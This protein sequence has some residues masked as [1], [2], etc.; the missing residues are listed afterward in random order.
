M[1]YNYMDPQAEEYHKAHPEKPVIGTETVSAVGTRGIYVT[2][3]EKAMWARTIRT[4]RR[5]APRRKAGGASAIRGSGCREDSC[6]RG[7][8][9]AASRRPMSGPTS[10]RSMELSIPAVSL[11]IRFSTTSRGGPTSR[12]LHLFPHWNWPGM[13]GKEIAVWVY[14]NLDKVELFFNGKSLGAKDMKKDSHVAW[15]VKYAP[16]AIEA[17][18]Y[19]GGKVVMTAKRETTRRRGEVGD[20]C[21]SAGGFGRWRGCGH[22]RGRGSGC[23]GPRCADHR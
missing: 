20:E 18:G 9:I 16:G 3:S 13:E 8:I 15:V 1:G 4:P 23:A 6:G 12:Y 11:R 21:G 14:S 2:D 22:V 19:K 10:A 17:R 7:S 5:V